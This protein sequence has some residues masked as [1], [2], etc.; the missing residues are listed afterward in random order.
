[1]R[2][3]VAITGGYETHYLE[4]GSGEP[5][6]LIHGGGAGADARGNWS[7]IMPHYVAAGFRVIAYDLLGFG[8]SSTPDPAAF[9][10][11]Q[12]S[13]NIQLR[14]LLDALQ[15]PSTS[16]IGNSMGGATALGLA[17]SDPGRVKAMVL[18]A[19]GGVNHD[20]AT[21]LA[22]LINYDFTVEG[23]RKIV[24][25]LTNPAFVINEEIVHYRHALSCE[26]GVRRAYPAVMGWIKQQGGLH[27]AEDQIAAGKTPTL[28]ISGKNDQVIP[29]ADSLRLLQLI[30]GSHGYFIPDCGHWAMMEYPELFAEVT[31]AFLKRE[32]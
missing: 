20:T 18:M 15:L 8:Q 12:P 29:M 1:M 17:M 19:S 16:I 24:G 4:D 28:V 13:R 26:P 14:G 9:T 2:D 7:K 6:I 21:G 31:I 23:M 5:L 22:P 32:P 25:A 30:E 11:D 27:Y 3:G 10:Y